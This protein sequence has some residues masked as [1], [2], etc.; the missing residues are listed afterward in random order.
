MAK[1]DELQTGR[2]PL[3][4]APRLVE[5]KS[6]N[7]KQKPTRV[8]WT[9]AAVTYRG[10][11][12]STAM[13]WGPAGSRVGPTGSHMA[14]VGRKENIWER[15]DF[16]LL[17][18]GIKFARSLSLKKRPRKADKRVDVHHHVMS[19]VHAAC[20]TAKKYVFF[21]AGR[22]CVSGQNGK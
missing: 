3:R 7:R 11:R 12:W 20:S 8:H 4:G 17:G 21:S 5:D 14:P 2:G 16:L 10:H 13:R 6:R 15:R 22:R 9:G 18:W 19:F 1:R